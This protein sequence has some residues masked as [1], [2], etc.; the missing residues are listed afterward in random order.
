MEYCFFCRS[1]CQ[2]EERSRPQ[3]LYTCPYCGEYEL[4]EEVKEDECKNDADFRAKGTAILQESQLQLSKRYFLYC[5]HD[6]TSRKYSDKVF[7]GNR[8]FLYNYPKDYLEIIDRVLLNIGHKT[9]FS[10]L[11]RYTPCER[12][13][14][15]FFVTP[16]L[17][18]YK[19][20]SPI[21]G[22]YP[23]VNKNIYKTISILCDLGYI[24]ENTIRRDIVSLNSIS[25]TPK[26]LERI[27]EIKD[28]ISKNDNPFL[29]MWFK[30]DKMLDK[31]NDA[32]DIA[33]K[34]AGYKAPYRVDKDKYNG[35]IMFEI[36]NRIKE[37]R[38]LIAD[39][40]CEY[41]KVDAKVYSK[42]G[43]RGGVYYE[44]G[45][46]EGLGIPVI[47]T[48]HKDCKAKNLVHFDLDQFNMILWEERN[49]E[50]YVANKNITLEK[51]MTEWIIKS[52]GA[53]PNK[54]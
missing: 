49:N 44:A 37:S 19:D 24:P 30:P 35:N 39:L 21:I 29:A 46:A 13:F 23:D 40:T 31:Y 53:G 32:V 20:P 6:I 51:E 28:N 7:V 52:V 41:K 33:T 34:N 54:Y 10:P 12:E 11:E 25:L 16:P 47:L 27:R 1:E 14:G 42:N 26:A 3:T 50:I 5:N 17:S 22:C 45:L 38:F 36:I 43:V 15:L 18:F 8:P 48:C 9:S 4:S 2:T